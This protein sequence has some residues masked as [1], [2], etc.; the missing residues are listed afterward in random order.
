M[1]EKSVS[2]SE[3]PVAK[4]AQNRNDDNFH[5]QSMRMY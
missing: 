5:L 2:E 3:K 4:L 1:D